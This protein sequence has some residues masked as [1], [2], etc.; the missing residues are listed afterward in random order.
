MDWRLKNKIKSFSE[1]VELAYFG[2]ITKQ[3][4]PSSLWAMYGWLQKK[5]VT[6]RK[7]SVRFY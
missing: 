6:V 2:E 3:F 7:T 1:N 4:K 5:T